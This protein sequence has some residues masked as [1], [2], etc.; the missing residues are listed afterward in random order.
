MSKRS[1]DNGQDILDSRDV[2]ARI[3]ELESEISDNADLP[4]DEQADMEEEKAELKALQALAEK[5]EG[6]ADWPHGE[7]LIRDS[8]FTDYAQDLAS[9]LY[10]EEIDDAHWPF[11]CID[12]EQAAS[13]L[14][15]DYTSVDFDGVTYWIRS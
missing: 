1:V 2:I 9:D 14:Q 5:G 11:D 6:S 15:Q 7:T 12:W 10:G 8:Y 3:D 13:A 4:E